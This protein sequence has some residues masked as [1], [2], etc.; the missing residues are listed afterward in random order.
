MPYALWISDF[1]TVKSTQLSALC[2]VPLNLA[3]HNIGIKISF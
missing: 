2:F 1:P 3:E